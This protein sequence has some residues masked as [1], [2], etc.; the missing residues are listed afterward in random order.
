MED[1]EVQDDI[2]Y[3][4]LLT[5]SALCINGS[6]LCTAICAKID[7]VQNVLFGRDH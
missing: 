6:V 1:G 3:S 4:L 7:T 5:R 2:R